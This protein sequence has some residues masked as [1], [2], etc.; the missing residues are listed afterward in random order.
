MESDSGSSSGDENDTLFPGS[1]KRKLTDSGNNF[2]GEVEDT[3]SGDEGEIDDVMEDGDGDVDDDDDVSADLRI[4]S[5]YESMEEEDEYLA[6]EI[7]FSSP[8]TTKLDA[9]VYAAEAMYRQ[10]LLSE[11]FDNGLVSILNTNNFVG[12][13]DDS[14]EFEQSTEQ[15][16]YG[17]G[18]PV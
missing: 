3:P 11:N 9:L 12:D 6:Q 16:I 1:K 2:D 8:A 18:S 7:L 5:P 4:S 17:H 13:F 14:L 15:S 10:E